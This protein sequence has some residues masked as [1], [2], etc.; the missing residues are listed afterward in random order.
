MSTT[1]L[2][3]TELSLGQA[4]KEI[5]I[6]ENYW[7]LDALTQG[8][9]QDIGYSDSDDATTTEG[10]L[11]YVNGT[12]ANDWAGHDGELAHYFNDS[13]H[14]Y[15]LQTGMRFWVVADT[16]VASNTFQVWNGA[17]WQVITIT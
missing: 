11:Y 15:T 2:V 3:L 9:L 16:G 8:I 13:W 12:G 4:S 14:F 10:Y 17:A 7:R 5:T 1:N 6:N